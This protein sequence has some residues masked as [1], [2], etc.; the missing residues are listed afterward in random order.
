MTTLLCLQPLATHPRPSPPIRP[1]RP[2]P[3]AP[4]ALPTP[5]SRSPCLLQASGAA[6]LVGPHSASLP[7]HRPTCPVTPLG[8]PQARHVLSPSKM[9]GLRAAC[10]CPVVPFVH[11]LVP[12]AAVHCHPLPCTHWLGCRCSHHGRRLPRPTCESW[13]QSPAYLQAQGAQGVRPPL[14]KPER[15]HVSLSSRLPQT[16]APT[17]RASDT[18]RGWATYRA[19]Q[20]GAPAPC[21]PGLPVGPVGNSG[22]AKPGP[23]AL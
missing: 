16:E 6:G 4:S 11:S 23:P 20:P 17:P 3:Q 19:T 5:S 2:P 13:F 14:P 21:I 7:E 18:E 10:S 9:L 1:S 12:S 15:V 22:Q 8:W